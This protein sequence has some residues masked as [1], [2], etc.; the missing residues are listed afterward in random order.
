MQTLAGH[1]HLVCSTDG[2]GG[3]Y[4]SH[5]SFSA[6]FHISKSYQSGHALMVQVINPTAG[7][8]AGDRLE[9]AIRVEHGARLHISTPSSTRIHTM[10]SGMAQTLQ[11]FHVAEGGWLEYSPASLIPQRRGRYRQTTRVELERGAELFFFETLAPGRVACG[12]CFEFHELDWDFSLVYDKQ[13]I[14]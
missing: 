7:L 1:L 11:S 3:S 6:P 12:E 4:I 2:A 13:L 8:F 14:A 9:S 10:H 5:Q